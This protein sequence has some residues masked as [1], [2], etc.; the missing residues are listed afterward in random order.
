[1][2]KITLLT[3][4]LAS[5]AAHAAEWV[6]VDTQKNGTESFV[7]VSS[8]RVEGGV[9]RFWTKDV[10]PPK[11]MRGPVGF[12][13]KWLNYL[14]AREAINCDDETYRVESKAAYWDD[15]TDL[16]A[17]EESLPTAWKPIPPDSRAEVEMRLICAWA[18][19]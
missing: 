16:S 14:L 18:A 3:V 17:P 4:L 9:R 11:T 2:Q 15:G 13:D 12:M 6:S 1:M 19:K 10:P 7:D 8:I 5:S